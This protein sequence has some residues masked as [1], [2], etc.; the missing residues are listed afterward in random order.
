[1]PLLGL[2][3]PAPAD[4]AQHARA[5]HTVV[6]VGVDVKLAV[7]L[8]AQQRHACRRAQ[9]HQF[10]FAVRGS[11]GVLASLL[12]HI[13]HRFEG[14]KACRPGD[15]VLITELRAFHQAAG[16]VQAERAVAHEQPLRAAHALFLEHEG[17]QHR[18]HGA[19]AVA[20]D[21]DGLV[22]AVAADGGDQVGQSARGVCVVSARRGFG[23]VAVGD[24]IEV[25]EVQRETLVLA[26]HVP[27][28][29]RAVLEGATAP[30][31]VFVQCHR[32]GA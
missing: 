25:L 1:M 5:H 6:R 31:I 15:N 18:H 26:E 23:Q 12:D 17:C 28:A 3:Q 21:V 8:A 10:Q 11:V 16:F 29:R 14:G 2:R 4:R 19:L 7:L 22:R 30:G 24:G 9:A 27:Q 13:G 32:V 20:D